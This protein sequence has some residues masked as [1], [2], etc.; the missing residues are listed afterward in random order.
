MAAVQPSS[1]IWNADLTPDELRRI[2]D[3]FA[4]VQRLVS[5]I[6]DRDRVLRSILEESQNIAE[7]EASSLL[8]YDEKSD[9][10]YF[11]VVLSDEGN[12]QALQEQVRLS[13]DE[14]IAGAAAK[15]RRSVNVRD[16]QSDNRF[17]PKADLLSTFKTHSILAVPMVDKDSLMGVVEVL[18]KIGGGGFTQTDQYVMELFAGQVATVL[19]NARLIEENLRSERAAAIG[20]A[21]AGMSHHIKNLLANLEVS[22]ELADEGLRDGNEHFFTKGWGVLKRNVRRVSDV[23]ADMLAFAKPRFPRCEWHDTRKLLDQLAET[24]GDRVQRDGVAYECRFENAPERVYMDAAGFER[25]ILNLLNNAFDAV[26]K[27]NGRV[28]LLATHDEFG[29]L[30]IKVQDNGP[31]I[32][33]QYSEKIF[34]PFYSTKGS[35]GT[36]LGLAV[37][38]K[39]VAEHGGNILLEPLDEGG[40]CFVLRFPQP[41]KEDEDTISGQS[42]PT[43]TD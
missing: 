31:G 3:A 7:A 26:P 42:E 20:L 34:D 2:L 11:H 18:N 28:H 1:S 13:L 16:V 8:L 32:P 35:A 24:I 29:A 37:T 27:L 38:R 5:N 17:Y 43:D 15:T 40:A 30:I 19:S 4:R 12:S 25:C 9:D 6:T 10:L 41:Y 33:L 39:I 14:G 36:G 21:M 23:V 22:L